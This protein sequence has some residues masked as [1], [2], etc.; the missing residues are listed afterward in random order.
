MKIKFFIFLLFIGQ[1]TFGQSGNH[2]TIPGTKFSM[3]PPEG[4][5]A[6]TDINGFQNKQLNASITIMEMPVSAQEFSQGFTADELSTKGMILVDKNIINFDSSKA[7][8][9]KIS[10][11]AN[12]TIYLKQLLVFGDDSRTTLVIG[13]YP[14]KNK[15]LETDIRNALLSTRCNESQNVDPLETVSFKIDVSET[16]FKLASYSTGGLIYTTD[17]IYPSDKPSLVIGNSIVK[18]PV[19]DK[20]QFCIDRLSKLSG[21][22]TREIKEINPITINNLTGYEIISNGKNK[23]LEE[24]LLYQN[25][26]FTDKDDFYFIVGNASENLDTYLKIFKNISQTFKRK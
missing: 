5:V 26:L 22:K 17:G 12:G 11:S 19:E 1:T 14:E 21:K 13:V 6:S 15:T 3:I 7:T 8:Y 18:V 10:Q 24:N 9:I 16:E 23:D 4:F 2:K 20:K 25:I